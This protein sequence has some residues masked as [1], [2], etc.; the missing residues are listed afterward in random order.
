MLK[1]FETHHDLKK[2]KKGYYM[3]LYVLSGIYCNVSDV[4]G[5]YCNVRTGCVC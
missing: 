3:R 1:L 5:I 4:S 2:K